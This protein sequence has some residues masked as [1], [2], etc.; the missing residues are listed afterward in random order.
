MW[1]AIF[2]STLPYGSDLEFQDE[3]GRHREFQSTLPYGSDTS[4]IRRS[5]RTSDFNPRSRM[6]ATR[7]AGVA[8]LAL[9][10]QS[11]LP[12]GSD[13]FQTLINELIN[14]ISIHAPV[15]E[16]PTRRRNLTT[17]PDF[18]PRSRMGAT[19]KA[20]YARPDDE[21]QSTLP[22][23]SDQG[24]LAGP[25]G[26]CISIHAPVWERPLTGATTYEQHKFQSTL[27]YGSDSMARLMVACSMIFQ[28]TL[29]Y[30]S[31]WP[32]RS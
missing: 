5:C 19:R 9:T 17:I 7:L 30:G 14:E 31:D 10:F 21:F 2:Q 28:S 18:N 8:E 15:W 12:Y 23:G 26:Q 22:Y 20:L 32:R 25:Q 16:R 27:P 3:D 4:P 11:T 29:P 1:R 24:P 13:P 6:G